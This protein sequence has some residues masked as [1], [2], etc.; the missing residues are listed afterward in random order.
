[1]NSSRAIEN[2]VMPKVLQKL[3]GHSSIKTTMDRYVYVN[4]KKPRK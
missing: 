1:M 2:G 4:P 3:L